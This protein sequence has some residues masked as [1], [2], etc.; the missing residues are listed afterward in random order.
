MAVNPTQAQTK[1]VQQTQSS[2]KSTLDLTIEAQSLV[3]EGIAKLKNGD[4]DGAQFNYLIAMDTLSN[5][6]FTESGKAPSGAYKQVKAEA[7]ELAKAL[8][9]AQNPTSSKPDESQSTFIAQNKKMKH[10]GLGEKSPAACSHTQAAAAKTEAASLDKSP[11]FA[12]VDLDTLLAQNSKK[13]IS[14]LGD[15]PSVAASLENIPEEEILGRVGVADEARTPKAKISSRDTLN[16]Y[17]NTE[18]QNP[19]FVAREELKA[20]LRDTEQGTLDV[21]R[22]SWNGKK[23]HGKQSVIGVMNYANNLE[24]KMKTGESEEVVQKAANRLK[25]AY[26]HF[27]KF[28]QAHFKGLT[29]HVVGKDAKKEVEDLLKAAGKYQAPEL[30]E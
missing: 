2:S 26:N 29:D 16:R 23:Y 3:N 30:T 27:Q 17:L 19:Q 9:E 18:F 14:E 1:N 6:A 20:N 21:V 22:E 24:T 11:V 12:E 5:P 15:G 8:G 7:G 25:G 13:L 10:L 4:I 28:D